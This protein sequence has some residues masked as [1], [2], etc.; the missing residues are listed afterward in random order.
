MATRQDMGLSVPA[1]KACPVQPGKEK[2]YCNKCVNAIA[3]AA[4]DRGY[5]EALKWMR[6]SFGGMD[7]FDERDR[8]KVI[9][10]LKEE[11]GIMED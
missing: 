2:L 11:M 1:E 7:W 9:A 4:R 8:D 10:R 6:G 3:D 5:A